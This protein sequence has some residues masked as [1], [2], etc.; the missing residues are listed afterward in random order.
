MCIFKACSEF[1]AVLGNLDFDNFVFSFFLLKLPLQCLFWLVSQFVCFVS[2]FR[3]SIMSD[4]SSTLLSHLV[5][6]SFCL[7][8]VPF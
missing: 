3:F 1:G 2:H 8:C 6:F 7:L 5:C 4:F